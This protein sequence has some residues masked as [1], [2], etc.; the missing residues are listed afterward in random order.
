MGFDAAILF[1]LFRSWPPFFA[2][3]NSSITAC[4]TPLA[5]GRVKG[6]KGGQEPFQL[7]FPVRH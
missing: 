6:K 4:S 3:P 5:C 1:I 2:E 7:L